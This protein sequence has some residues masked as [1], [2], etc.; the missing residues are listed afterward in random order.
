MIR[1]AAEYFI[2]CSIH[3]IHPT[4]F[5]DVDTG[6]CVAMCDARTDQPHACYQDGH[7]LTDCFTDEGQSQL[8]DAYVHMIT[9]DDYEVIQ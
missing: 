7:S 5:I 1:L 4:L 2:I 9:Q 8:C 6:E 3:A